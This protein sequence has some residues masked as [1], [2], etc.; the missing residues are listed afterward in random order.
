MLCLLEFGLETV[1]LVLVVSESPLGT[2]CI[3]SPPSHILSQS[4]LHLVLL[5]LEVVQVL[6]EPRILVSVEQLPL[7]I[8]LLPP[9][10]GSL[11]FEILG[12]AV[13]SQLRDLPVQSLNH[14]VLTLEHVVELGL[15]RDDLVHLRLLPL[16]GELHLLILLFELLRLHLE[17]LF[18]T[19]QVPRLVLQLLDLPAVLDKLLVLLESEVVTLSSHLSGLGCQ[20]LVLSSRLIQVTPKLLNEFPVPPVIKSG[21][22]SLVSDGQLVDFRAHPLLQVTKL[23]VRLVSSGLQLGLVHL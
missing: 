17:P 2:L 1:E 21:V 22:E 12:L 16:V 20:V 7:P 11:C 14:L 5:L 3:S 23:F 18:V 6:L 10:Q 19:L 4:L 9:S 13:V 8:F 15:L